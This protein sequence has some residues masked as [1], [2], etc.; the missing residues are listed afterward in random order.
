M[1]AV[2]CSSHYLISV[3]LYGSSSIR[4]QKPYRLFR[5]KNEFNQLLVINIKGVAKMAKNEM[6]QPKLTQE[7]IEA[8]KNYKKN[9][10]IIND[11]AEG[12]RKI[13]G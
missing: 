6:Q 9:I 12:V 7:Q 3:S 13:P 4:L 11:Y 2:T 10:K 8:I 1:Y 5:L